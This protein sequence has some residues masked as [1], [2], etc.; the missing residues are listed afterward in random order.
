[1]SIR[2][3]FCFSG[4]ASRASFAALAEAAGAAVSEGV[5]ATTT[6][7]VAGPGAEDEVAAAVANG[8]LTVW[9]EDEFLRALGGGGGGG[10]EATAEITNKNKIKGKRPKDEAAEATTVRP[11]PRLHCLPFLLHT[12]ITTHF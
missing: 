6:H 7:L 9:T 12:A 1:M 4:V 10:G 11:A 5:T 2:Q 8:E 3:V